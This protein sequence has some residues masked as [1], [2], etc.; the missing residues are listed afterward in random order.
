LIFKR[1]EVSIFQT[2][3]YILGCEH[4]HEALVIE[5]GDNVE[6]I[7]EVL[8]REHLSLIYI[9]NTHGHGPQTTIGREKSYDPFLNS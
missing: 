9:L 1:L 7:T 3:C 4:T 5:P 6:R 2:N 8:K